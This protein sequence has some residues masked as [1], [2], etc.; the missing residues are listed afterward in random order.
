MVGVRWLAVRRV[1]LVDPPFVVYQCSVL[2][3][4]FRDRPD[5]RLRPR[6]PAQPCVRRRHR[7]GSARRLTPI[8]RPPRGVHGRGVVL[9][10]EV[11][12]GG[13]REHLGDRTADDQA[14]RRWSGHG[15]CGVSRVV[16][17][18]AGRRT[19]VLVLFVSGQVHGQLSAASGDRPHARCGRRV[20]A[21]P[22]R[23]GGGSSAA[24]TRTAAPWDPELLDL[25][26]PLAHP[27]VGRSLGVRQGC[28]PLP[29]AVPGRRRGQR[30][31]ACP[32]P[33]RCRRI[34]A[35]RRSA[36]RRSCQATC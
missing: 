6:P 7:V 30:N 13:C 24:S 26:R 29:I 3:L 4:T 33:G 36:E 9:R 15:R 14:S 16:A 21:C 35:P 17:G 31:H 28:V 19:V 22:Q 27:D 34:R 2:R 25:S 11:H 10:S 23:S 18:R 20:L 12:T 8:R 5:L 1:E 32:H